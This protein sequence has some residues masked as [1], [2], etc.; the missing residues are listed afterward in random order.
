MKEG[1]EWRPAAV[2]KKAVQPRSYI[3]KLESGEIV[4]RNR[5]Q[6][7]PSVTELVLDNKNVEIG[8]SSNS[9]RALADHESLPDKERPQLAREQ[10]YVTRSGRQSRV[11]HRYG[12]YIM[13]F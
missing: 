8:P 10:M 4:R 7:M 9:N 5:F 1:N 6:L 3:V 2:L 13:D 11:P 12:D